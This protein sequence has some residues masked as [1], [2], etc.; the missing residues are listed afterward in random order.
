MTFQKYDLQLTPSSLKSWRSSE[1]GQK[2]VAVLMSGGVDSSVTAYLLKEAGWNVMGLTMKIPVSTVG[3]TT[4]CC[5]AHAALVCEGLDLPHYFVDVT[6]PFA[7]I[8]IEPFRQ[9][10]RQGR[11]PN[12][13]VDCNSKLKL[14]LLWDF[15]E[16]KYGIEHIATG[17]YAR[18]IKTNG[19]VVLARAADKIKDQSY[20][21]YDIRAERIERL[22]LPLGDFTKEQVRSIAAGLNLSVAERSESMELCF[23]GEGD[24]RAVL[25]E[26]DLNQEGRLQDMQGQTIGTHKGIV[27]YTIGQ[28][29]GVGFAGGL[30]LYVASIDAGTNTITL[31]NREEVSHPIIK[32]NQLNISIP[33]KLR[34]GQ[35]LSGKLRSYSHSH[36]CR[37]VEF[38]DD[39]LTVRFDRPVFAPCPGQRLVLYD[40]NDYIVGGGTIISFGDYET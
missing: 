8:I 12:P 1:T 24:Y 29:R 14:G 6:G 39:N 11:T 5:S 17:H 36:P 34:P 32:A 15:L 25:A 21:L 3:R 27:N 16:E 38:N 26:A 7:E 20:F 13:C 22:V 9:S 10:Y 31:G 4:G 40:E 2:S 18:V 30:P 28:R 33:E 19:R 23:A 35:N 37:V